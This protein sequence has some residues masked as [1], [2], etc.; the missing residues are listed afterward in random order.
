M[1]Y[2]NPHIVLDSSVAGSFQLLLDSTILGS[3]FAGFNFAGFNFSW[4]HLLLDSSFADFAGFNFCW[5]Q[6]ARVFCVRYAP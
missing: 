6:E 4:I 1:V 5:I 3:S 2:Y